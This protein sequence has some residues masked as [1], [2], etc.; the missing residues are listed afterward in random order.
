MSTVW[1]VETSFR[2][3][4]SAGAEVSPPRQPLRAPGL[5]PGGALAGALAPAV[6][7]WAAQPRIESRAVARPSRRRTYLVAATRVSG[8]T[9]TLL[10]F[11]R[12]TP[13][14]STTR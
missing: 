13:R 1:R 6:F 11:H 4:G 5:S 2:A 12:C 7:L 8:T 14:R 10:I 9:A 3:S